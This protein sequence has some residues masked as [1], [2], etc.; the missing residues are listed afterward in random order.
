ME[1]TAH[2]GT[3]RTSLRVRCRRAVELCYQGGT[4]DAFRR[5]WSVFW[6]V[7]IARSQKTGNRN[8]MAEY[9]VE[10]R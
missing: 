3:S 6:D 7:F 2:R 9:Y 10:V 5:W 4:A 1:G 8:V